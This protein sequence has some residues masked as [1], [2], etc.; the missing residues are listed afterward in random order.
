V[1][2]TGGD[3]YVRLWDPANAQPLGPPLAGH[4]GRVYS[5]RHARHRSGDAV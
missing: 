1:L 5:G 4:A 2:A 3:N